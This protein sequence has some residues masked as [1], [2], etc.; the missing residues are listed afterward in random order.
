MLRMITWVVFVGAIACLGTDGGLYRLRA[1]PEPPNEPKDGEACEQAKCSQVSAMWTGKK[2][3]PVW[4][5]LEEVGT[6]WV[7][8]DR[9]Y[10]GL[11]VGK[12]ANQDAD[13]HHFG[14][15]VLRRHECTKTTYACKSPPEGQRVGVSLGKDSVGKW[16]NTTWKR[17]TCLEGCPPGCSYEPDQ[18][19]ADVGEMRVYRNKDRGT[20]PKPVTDLTRSHSRQSHK[21]RRR[22]AL[23]PGI[24]QRNQ[25]I[26][27]LWQWRDT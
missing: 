6:K 23:L 20:D 24:E 3:D 9:A 11:Y 22:R 10:K 2:K 1:D 15:N 13:V 16:D 27:L 5:T 4:A 8:C 14:A 25:D 26:A 12:T 7:P 17:A 19:F 18:D 21:R